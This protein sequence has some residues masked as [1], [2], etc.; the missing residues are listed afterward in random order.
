MRSFRKISAY[1]YAFSTYKAMDDCH[2]IVKGTLA[3]KYDI[4][5]NLNNTWLKVSNCRVSLCKHLIKG[6]IKKEKCK[7]NSETHFIIFK[8]I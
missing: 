3:S 7:R 6:Y 5:L 4:H 8:V 2:G 1:A